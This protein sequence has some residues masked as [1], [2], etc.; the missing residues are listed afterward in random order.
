[1]TYAIAQAAER[2]GLSIDTLRYYERI[3]LV[4]PP[5]RDSGGRRSYTDEDLSWL[6]FLTKL[7]TTGMPIRMMREYAQLRMRGAGTNSRRR[8]ILIDHRKDVLNRIAELQTCLE[9]LNYKINL[10]DDMVQEAS[11]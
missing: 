1:M 11:A 2:S 7:R 10:Y 5:A 4:E 8:Q 9:A 6:E 3:G